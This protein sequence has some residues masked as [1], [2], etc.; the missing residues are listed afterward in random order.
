MTYCVAAGLE[1]QECPI[2][3]FKIITR[4]DFDSDP[5]AFSSYTMASVR[6]PVTEDEDRRLL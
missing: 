3:D 6:E 1:A 4:S 5:A 2:L